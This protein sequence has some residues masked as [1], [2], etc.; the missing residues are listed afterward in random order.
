LLADDPEF[1]R[2]DVAYGLIHG[3][4]TSAKDA[5]VED[6]LHSADDDWASVLKALLHIRSAFPKSLPG[7]YVEGPSDF[8]LDVVAEFCLEDAMPYFDDH[9]EAAKRLEDT[10][11]QLDTHDG[12]GHMHVNPSEA[13]T[14]ALTRGVSLNNE[15]HRLLRAKKFVKAEKAFTEA[16]RLKRNAFPTD[17]VHTCIGLSGLAELYLAWGKFD[18]DAGKLRRAA[19]FANEMLGIAKRMSHRDHVR[20]AKEILGDVADAR[21]ALRGLE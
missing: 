6:S 13:A 18:S 17:S 21:L 7:E 1:Q 15:G 20:V 9:P 19:D 10:S 8:Q 4:L 2:E 12:H 14:I 16:M 11:V 5:D 3:A